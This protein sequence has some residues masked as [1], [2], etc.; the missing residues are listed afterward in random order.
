MNKKRLLVSLITVGSVAVL[1]LAATVAFYS[2]TEISAD[3]TFTA[4]ELDLQIDNKFAYYRDHQVESEGNWPL[5]DLVDEKFFDFD[6]VKPGDYG[7]NTISMHVYNNDA[8]MCMRIDNMQN[9]ENGCNDPESDVDGNCGNPGPGEGELAQKLNFFAWLDEGTVDGFQGQVDDEKEG[10][11]VW[12]SANEL[13][14]FTNTIGPAS[15]V[16]NGVTYTLA[17]STFS[18][19]GSGPFEGSTTYYM[20]VAWCAGTLTVA[21]PAGTG[22]MVVNPDLNCD[23]VG[24]GNNTQSD[25]LL[26]DIKFYAEQHRNDADFDCDDVTFPSPP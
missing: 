25:S 23:G 4:G 6:D 16:L 24:M 17:D 15:D 12:Q 26:A 2:D 3:N 20:G 11:N 10:D 8:W 7:E 21:N 5:K 13:P 9:N 1:A 19:L 18:V 14:L 22:N